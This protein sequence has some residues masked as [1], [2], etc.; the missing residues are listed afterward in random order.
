MMIKSGREIKVLQAGAGQVRA[1]GGGVQ[2]SLHR[3]GSRG[4]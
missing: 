2:I 3:R 1:V 4:R